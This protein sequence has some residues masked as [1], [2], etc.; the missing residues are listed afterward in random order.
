[1]EQK[2]MNYYAPYINNFFYVTDEFTNDYQSKIKIG[3]EYLKGCNIGIVGLGRNIEDRIP[4][5]K[6]FIQTLNQFTNTQ[7]F[8]YENDSIDNTKNLLSEISKDIDGFDFTSEI[9]NNK[10]FAQTREKERTENLAV[11]RNK[12]LEYAKTNFRHTDYI[13]VLDTDFLEISLEGILHTFGCIK[14]NNK[15]SAMCGVSYEHKNL[16]NMNF[17]ALWN[18]D[19][20]AYRPTW[21]EDQSKYS[22]DMN[23]MLWFGLW[24]PPIGSPPIPVNS[25]F[26]ACCVYKTKDYVNSKY[27]GYDCEHVCFHKN[28]K[29][30]N[31][32][33][34][35]FMNPSQIVLL[36]IK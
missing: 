25:G 35:L 1:M 22:K 13:L 3:Y 30:N 18:Y 23:N 15:I 16:F 4:N 9:L 11:Y 8:I 5:L 12:C 2:F 34:Q 6:N 7:T 20:W 36:D 17:K 10:L 31:P 21:W 28:L 19:S 29:R 14:T 33:F 26:G 27:E 24:C 32:D